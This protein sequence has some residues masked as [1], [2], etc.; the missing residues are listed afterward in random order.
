MSK[1]QLFALFVCSL[2]PYVVGNGLLP[3]LPVYAAHLGAESAEAGY[4]LSI[5]YLADSHPTG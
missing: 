4:Y 5:S 2:V 1:K 3:L